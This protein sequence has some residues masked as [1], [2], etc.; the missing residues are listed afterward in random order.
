[1]E[2]GRE[3]L[4]RGGEDGSAG[5]E[6]GLLN[7]LG[8]KAYGEDLV[9][10]VGEETDVGNTGRGTCKGA[11]VF[12]ED[13]E[14]TVAV[15]RPQDHDANKGPCFPRSETPVAEAD[16]QAHNDSYNDDEVHNS[17]GVGKKIVI[18]TQ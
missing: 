1:M 11:E 9:C 3:P 13:G 7:E 16:E 15:V 8:R 12:L 4:D 2:V 17:S 10:I 18:H 14:R 6:G 5:K